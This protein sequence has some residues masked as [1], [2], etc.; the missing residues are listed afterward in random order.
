M[1]P[2]LL[3]QIIRLSFSSQRTYITL[4][5]FLNPLSNRKPVKLHSRLSE[6]NTM[7]SCN[8]SSRVQ[9]S[10]L[11]N[12]GVLS[13]SIVLNTDKSSYVF[14]CGEGTQR[15]IFEHNKYFIFTLV[16]FEII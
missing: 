5:P 12:G 4:V 7:L 2:K 6:M 1:L 9:V 10:V 11:G 15:M 3:S 13:P 14:N 8:V 16:K